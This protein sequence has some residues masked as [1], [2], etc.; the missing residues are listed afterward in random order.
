MKHLNN[1]KTYNCMKNKVMLSFLIIFFLFGIVVAAQETLGTFKQG[2]QVVIKQICG[3]CTF[4]NITSITYPNSTEI[5]GSSNIAMSKDS[6]EFTHTLS[7][8]NTTILGKYFVHGFGDIEGIKTA[9]VVPFTITPSGNSGNAFIVFHIFLIFILYGIT[10][11]GFFGKN[12]WMSLIGSMSLIGLG[13]YVIQQG[14]ILFRDWLTLYFAYV[15]I[16]IGA[17]IALIAVIALINGDYE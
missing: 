1:E 11:F 2:E 10:F 3:T 5:F 9:W 13:I 12:V 8:A 4:N 17:A 6:A 7:G 15:T 16:G 14:I